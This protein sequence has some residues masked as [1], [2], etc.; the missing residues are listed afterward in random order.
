[1]VWVNGF[2][3]GFY[4]ISLAVFTRKLCVMKYCFVKLLF[5]HSYHILNVFLTPPSVI[6]DFVPAVLYPCLMCPCLDKNLDLDEEL[7][8]H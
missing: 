6:F 8:C 2:S 5:P 4:G 1:M 3:V 7:D